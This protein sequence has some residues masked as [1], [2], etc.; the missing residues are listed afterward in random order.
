MSSGHQAHQRH[1]I[2]L[3]EFDYTQPGA[4]FLI[5]VTEGRACIFGEVIN[6]EMV[7]SR[8]GKIARPEVSK[9]EGQG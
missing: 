6:G 3:K 8:F 1:S 9:I 2:R 5:I 4:Y 7:L